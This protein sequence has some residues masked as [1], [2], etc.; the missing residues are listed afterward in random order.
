MS[1]FTKKG[2]D[3]VAAANAA[4]REGVRDALAQAKSDKVAFAEREVEKYEAKAVEYEAKGKTGAAAR[5]RK[6]VERNRR[7]AEKHRG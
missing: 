7:L 5:A 4:G 6:V 1:L 2:R 3:E